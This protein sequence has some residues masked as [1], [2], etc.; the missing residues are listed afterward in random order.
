M[1]TQ[2]QSRSRRNQRENIDLTLKE[3]IKE[4]LLRVLNE[5]E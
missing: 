5:E 3:L 1:P 4:E 2:Q